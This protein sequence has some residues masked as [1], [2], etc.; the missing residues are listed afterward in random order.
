MGYNTSEPWYPATCL[1]PRDP[2][3]WRG[4]PRPSDP[5][6]LEKAEKAYQLIKFMGPEE[7]K[8]YLYSVR[9]QVQAIYDENPW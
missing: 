6:F 4:R 1:N 8:E 7:Y 2:D 9:D 5:E 3:K